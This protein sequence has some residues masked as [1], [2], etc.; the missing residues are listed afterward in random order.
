MLAQTFDGIESAQMDEGDNGAAGESGRE[1]TVLEP[2]E[3]SCRDDS[4]C[5]AGQIC[6]QEVCLQADE[7]CGVVNECILGWGRDMRDACIA[8]LAGPGSTC[9]PGG[10]PNRSGTCN[11]FGECIPNADQCERVPICWQAERLNEEC[12]IQ[13]SPA[14]VPCDDG[15]LATNGDSCDGDGQCIGEALACPQAS[16]CVDFEP[17][18]T[19][20]QPVYAAPETPCDDGNSESLND[21]CDGQGRCV[22]FLGMCP[23]NSACL[24][25]EL[26]TDVC[27]VIRAPQ[28]TECSD[29]N[30]AT[31]EDTCSADGVCVGALSECPPIHSMQSICAQWY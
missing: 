9:Q 13:P 1:N 10:D 11:D 4:E 2:T 23:E 29:E 3:D 8:R 22:G 5:E 17:N 24:S 31:I 7:S 30:V 14:G 21:Q 25:W 26:G 19:N 28:G 6:V 12:F 15:E 18:G 27:R 16:T 20:C